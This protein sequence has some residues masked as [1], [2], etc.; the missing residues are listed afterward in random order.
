MFGR[1]K[2]I[3]VFGRIRSQLIPMFGIIRSEFQ[4]LEEIRSEFQCL[5]GSDHNSNVWKNKVNTPMFRRKEIRIPVLKKKVTIPVFE[6][7]RPESK[8]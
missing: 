7:I 4:C 5:E 6:R 3:P 1:N 8:K 2:Q